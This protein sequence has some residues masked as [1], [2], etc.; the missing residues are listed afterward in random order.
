MNLT[1]E[2]ILHEQLKVLRAKFI[3]LLEDRIDALEVL[4]GKI[5]LEGERLEALHQTQFIAHKISGTAGTLGFAEF[6]RL[7]AETENTIIQH[8]SA[9]NSHPTLED[10]KRVINK[11]LKSAVEL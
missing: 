2:K 5:D 10:T 8:L 1:A 3:D 4:R 6:G 7:A 9:K 11:F